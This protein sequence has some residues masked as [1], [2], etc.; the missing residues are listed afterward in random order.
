MLSWGFAFALPSFP[1]IV[2]GQ[3][4]VASGSTIVSLILPWVYFMGAVF[5]SSLQY[6]TTQSK[7]HVRTIV[8]LLASH[9]HSFRR[10]A[11]FSNWFSFIFFYM[12]IFRFAVDLCHSPILLSFTVHEEFPV[13]ASDITKHH[14]YI[15][16]ICE[17]GEKQMLLS[18][19]SKYLLRLLEEQCKSHILNLTK[20]KRNSV[21]RAVFPETTNNWPRLCPKSPFI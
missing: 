7:P 8:T 15:N 13:M 21:T 18:N 20:K 11:R 9:A 19:A 12:I 6:V 10:S 16:F 1:F 17:K 3:L 5:Q 14:Q 4:V 2:F